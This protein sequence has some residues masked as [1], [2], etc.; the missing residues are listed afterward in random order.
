MGEILLLLARFLSK[1]S[2]PATQETSHEILWYFLD[3]L[4]SFC[5]EEIA[6]SVGLLQVLARIGAG[7][8]IQEDVSA[9]NLGM[10]RLTESQRMRNFLSA[11][12]WP[13]AELT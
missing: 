13:M 12:H 1:V 5:R 7:S 3:V 11:Q 8:K 10:S 6:S 2:F 4:W 9:W